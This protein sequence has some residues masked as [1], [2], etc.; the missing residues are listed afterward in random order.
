MRLLLVALTTSSLFAQ[1]Q[2]HVDA[3]NAPQRIFHAHMTMPAQAGPL[4]LVYPKWIPGEH[5][6]TGPIIN[7]VG[8]KITAGGQP[9]AWQRDNVN[10]YAFHLNVPAGATSLDVDFDYLPPSVGPNFSSGSSTTSELAVLNWNQVILYPEGS[11]PDKLQYQATLRV[12]KGWRYGTALAIRRE[13][14]DEIEFQPVAA[15]TLVDSPVSAGRYYRTI[16]LGTDRGAPHYVHLAADS[17][18]ALEMSPETIQEYKNVVAETGALF[19]SRHYRS[20][21][22]LYTLS[23]HVRSFGLEHHESS[24]DR[25]LERSVVDPAFLKSSAYLLPHEMVHSWNGKFRRPEGLATGGYE[26]P[27]KGDLLWVY[28]G[29]TNYLGEVIAARAGLWTPEEYRDWLALTAANLDA[30]AGRKWRP[31]EDT[32]VMAQAL[33]SADDEYSEY[34]RSTDFYPEGTL[35]WLDADVLIRKLSNGSKSLN[36]FCRAFHGGPGGVPAVKPYS[37]E[38]IVAALNSVQPYDWAK[39]LNDR[40]HL[41][42]PHAP[43]GGITGSGWKLVF[44]KERSSL[45]KAREDR[46]KQLDLMYSI[47]MRLKEDGNVIDVAFD[48]PAKKAGVPPAS[49]LI[50]IDGRQYSPAV[51]REAVGRRDPIEVLIKDGEYYRTYRLDYTGG[52]RYPHLQRDPAAADLLSVITAPLASQR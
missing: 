27:M 12:P 43:L 4:T 52:E 36:D 50:A 2:L 6:S 31:L 37:F 48:G 22:F 14:G 17:A 26:L 32:A 51:L 42:T 29:L 41:V 9:V 11:D 21:H 35:I 40:V 16:D 10:M 7:L 46:D 5:M 28:E 15:S 23:D 49:Q 33:Y 45:Q 20:Y 30:Q 18:S 24:D 25:S 47:G 13:S 3:S 38:D 19:G 8:L 44:E 1:I 34:R 39:F